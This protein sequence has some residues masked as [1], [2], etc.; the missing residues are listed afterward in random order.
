MDNMPL[1]HIPLVLLLQVCI[2]PIAYELERVRVL[3]GV[4]FRLRVAG[5]LPRLS[6]PVVERRDEAERPRE[7]RLEKLPGPHGIIYTPFDRTCGGCQPRIIEIAVP[8]ALG[9]S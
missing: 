7:R 4:A 5:M 6:C 3:T 1:V 2:H 9:S 8:N